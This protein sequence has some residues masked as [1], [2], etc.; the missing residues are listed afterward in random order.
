MRAD[1]AVVLGDRPEDVP[2]DE[3]LVDH[4]LDSIRLM[5]LVER[6]REEGAAVS[7]TDLADRATVRAWAG[8]LARAHRRRGVPRP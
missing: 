2:L 3:D 7:A 8:V 6:W 5:T 4:G 1:V